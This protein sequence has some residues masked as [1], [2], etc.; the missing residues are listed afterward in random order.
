MPSYTNSIELYSHI[1]ITLQKKQY[2]VNPSRD[3]LYGIQF[4]IFKDKSSEM[5]RIYEGKNGIRLDFSEVK[6]KTFLHTL[7]KDLDSIIQTHEDPAPLFDP[8]E[9]D[10]EILQNEQDDPDDV[11]GIAHAGNHN[12]FG[13]LVIASVRLSP[14]DKNKILGLGI[15]NYKK[16][17]D[18]TLSYTANKIR[19]KL[20]HTSIT[21]GNESYNDIFDKFKNLNHLLAWNHLKLIEDNLKQGFCANVLS[22]QYG[23]GQ[24]LKKSLL[25]KR[26]NVTLNQRHHCDTNLAVACAQILATDTLKYQFEKMKKTYSFSFP[27]GTSLNVVEA[28]KDFLLKYDQ[29]ELHSVAK[30]HFRITDQLN[31]A[32]TFPN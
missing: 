6:Q 15:H 31:L 25:A 16:L 22:E 24:L 19:S 17:N 11:I 29:D 5:L 1:K 14:D 28:T 8:N 13:P 9:K 3:I 10:I 32:N 21:L 12:F 7:R 27:E 23:N 4:L 18:S 20:Q 30:E 26:I 2:I